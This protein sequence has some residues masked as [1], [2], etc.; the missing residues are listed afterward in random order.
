MR[1]TVTGQ[2]R[3][4]ILWEAVKAAG[5]TAALGRLIGI[6]NQSQLGNF[7]NLRTAPTD[8]WRDKHWDRIQLVLLN[9][10]GKLVEFEE[11]WPV[12][13]RRATPATTKGKPGNHFEFS[14]DV[15][16]LRMTDASVR[17]QLVEASTR[18]VERSNLSENLAEALKV[19]TPR[20][21]RLVEMRFGIGGEPAVTLQEAGERLGKE[22][23]SRTRTAQI[24]REALRKLRRAMTSSKEREWKASQRKADAVR[25]EADRSRRAEKAEAA[26]DAAIRWRPRV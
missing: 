16:P 26:L 7:L 19:L 3:N 5:S 25:E 14:G 2:V 12:E 10:I 22:R 8:G 6:S 23:V 11:V 24:E 4:G 9:L 17:R 1:I 18:E 20:E 21:L 13:F 15:D